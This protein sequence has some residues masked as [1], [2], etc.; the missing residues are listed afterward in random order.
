MDIGYQT[1]HYTIYLVRGSMEALW[2]AKN[3]VQKTVCTQSVVISMSV[4][5]NTLS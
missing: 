4:N 3:V 1:H 5:I 2:H